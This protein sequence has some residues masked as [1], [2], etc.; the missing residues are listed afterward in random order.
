M[1]KYMITQKNVIF[2]EHQE[3][4]KYTFSKDCIFT[5]CLRAEN[6]YENPLDI[7]YL[8]SAHPCLLFEAILFFALVRR[9][10]INHVAV[11]AVYLYINANARSHPLVISIESFSRTV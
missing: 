11:I 10:A 2:H 6:T 4:V 3:W 9:C 1:Y 8:S 5:E 7:F